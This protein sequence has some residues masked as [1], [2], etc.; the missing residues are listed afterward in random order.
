M[1][2]NQQIVYGCTYLGQPAKAIIL[3]ILSATINL[4]NGCAL[5]LP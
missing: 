2:Q 1:H 4:A 3:G 5:N